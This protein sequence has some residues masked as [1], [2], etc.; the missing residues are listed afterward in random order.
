MMPLTVLLHHGLADGMHMAQFYAEV[1]RRLQ[2][3]QV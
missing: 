1:E 3:F 2:E